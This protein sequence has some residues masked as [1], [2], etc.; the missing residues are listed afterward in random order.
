MKWDITQQKEMGRGDST[1]FDL[2]E[3]GDT[4]AVLKI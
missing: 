2:G 4:L 1:F 3:N